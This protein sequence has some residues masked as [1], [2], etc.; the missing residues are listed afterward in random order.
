VENCDASVAKAA[1]AGG[2]IHKPGTDI[3]HVG[4]FAVIGDPQG[5][6]FSI[7]QLLPA[8]H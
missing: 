4:R 3:E 7:I 2:Q 6:A 8:A 1:S 5:A